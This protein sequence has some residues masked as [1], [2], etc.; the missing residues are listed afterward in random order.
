MFF[1][2]SNGNI[3]YSKINGDEKGQESQCILTYSS[4][5]DFFDKTK[6]DK[7]LLEVIKV[8]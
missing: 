5:N 4:W 7:K 2:S 6:A 3:R 8:K 1:V